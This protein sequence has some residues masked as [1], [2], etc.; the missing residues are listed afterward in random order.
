MESETASGKASSS[1]WTAAPRAATEMEKTARRSRI[2]MNRC[3]HDPI[4]PFVGKRIGLYRQ[5]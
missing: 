3:H 1:S 4:S 2:E 5:N